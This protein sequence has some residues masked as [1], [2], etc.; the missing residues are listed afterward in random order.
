MVIDTSALVAV[1]RGEVERRNFLEAI[2]GAASRRM[3][4]ATLVETSMV[5]EARYGS[6]GLRDLDRLISTAGIEIISVDAEQGQIARGAFSRFGKGRHPAA[7]NF[8]DCFSYALAIS[9]GE[10][11]L[12]KGNDFPQTDITLAKSAK[13]YS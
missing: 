10:H 9:L 7:L 8:G 13:P 11:L 2:E 12:C 5:I 4:V 6:E 1:L 3:S